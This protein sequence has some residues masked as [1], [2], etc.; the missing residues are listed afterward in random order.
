MRASA[1]GRRAGTKISLPLEAPRIT[2]SLGGSASLVDA[3]RIHPLDDGRIAAEENA[4]ID[5]LERSQA[6]V[7]CA[8]GIVLR[9][10]NKKSL[11]DPGL[12][13]P[14]LELPKAGFQ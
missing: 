6:G 3:R 14:S 4:G 9:R 11:V 5:F 10:P 1:A 12:F 13:Q 8:A 2:K 7:R